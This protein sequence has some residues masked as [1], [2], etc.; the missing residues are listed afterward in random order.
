[1]REVG[2]VFFI[3]MN[4]V[5]VYLCVYMCVYVHLYV[6]V[7][8]GVRIYTCVWVYETVYVGLRLTC[9]I[10]GCMYMCACIYIYILYILMN[11]CSSE[12]WLICRSYPPPKSHC[13]NASHKNPVFNKGFVN[14]LRIDFIT[15]RP[16]EVSTHTRA[17]HTRAVHTR[18]DP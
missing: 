11:F 9:M 8:V 2:F 18:A 15:C 14:N 13:Q 7:Y 3:C 1:M 6:C 12:F 17:A 16:I 5:N 10:C 4:V